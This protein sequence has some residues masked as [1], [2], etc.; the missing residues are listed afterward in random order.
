MCR[1]EQVLRKHEDAISSYPHVNPQA[2][3][4][5]PPGVNKGY[6]RA[7]QKIIALA[8]FERIRPSYLDQVGDNAERGIRQFYDQ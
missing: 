8:D 1:M 4:P 2:N 5:A 7:F 6:I 3:I